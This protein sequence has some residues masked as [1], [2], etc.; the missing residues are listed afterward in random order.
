M[1]LFFFFPLNLP[2]F[3]FPF[4][5]AEDGAGKSQGPD[6]SPLPHHIVLRTVLARHHLGRGLP[7]LSQPGPQST[8]VVAG[9]NISVSTT[10]PQ[11]ERYEHIGYKATLGLPPMPWGVEDRALLNFSFM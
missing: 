4:F 1:L 7:L 6:G 2:P 9:R 8:Q 5:F 3:P 11:P 10:L